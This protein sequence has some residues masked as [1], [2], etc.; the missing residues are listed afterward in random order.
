MDSGQPVD[1][2]FRKGKPHFSYQ[3][4]IEAIAFPVTSLLISKRKIEYQ[5]Y[6]IL[7]E[8]DSAIAQEITH[9]HIIFCATSL[10][11]RQKYRDVKSSAKELV[12][13]SDALCE[14]NGLSVICNPQDK[15][16]PYDK[17]AVNWKK[18]SHRDDLRIMIDAALRHR[19]DGFDALLQMLEDAG[20]RI[21]RGAHIS[22]KPPDGQRYIRLKSLG[23]EYDEDTLRQALAGDHV[24]IPKTPCADY[25]KS[26]IKRLIDIEDKL[27]AGKGK[28]YLV[29]AERNNIDAIS[30]TV[31]F[32]KEHHLGSSEELEQQI[33]DLQSAHDEKKASI[34]QAQNRMKEINRQRQAIRDY[35][36]TKENTLSLKNPAGQQNSI[37]SI[38]QKSK[39]TKKHKLSTSFTTA[40]CR[41]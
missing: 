26:Q 14:E 29:W 21:R 2:A 36:R 16:V 24:H 17:W 18:S 27:R 12:Q 6:K 13:I 10:D 19:P 38:A 22:L 25:S 40:N 1:G 11:G 23:P 37:R 15:A 41:R 20:C 31:I 3:H 39:H 7:E 35:R 28:G 32:L 34:R 4:Y 30:Q 33:D 9:N 8:R 5:L